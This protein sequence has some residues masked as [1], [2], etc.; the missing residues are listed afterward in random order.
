MP[1]RITKEGGI[2]K[3]DMIINF[4]GQFKRLLRGTILH[5]GNL[6]PQAHHKFVYAGNNPVN[7]IDPQ[8]LFYGLPDYVIGIGL[9][10]LGL[11]FLPSPVGWALIASGAVIMITNPISEYLIK[12]PLERIAREV[13]KRIQER[14][15]E[16]E[17]ILKG[18]Y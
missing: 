16:I 18:K 2:I 5:M 4:K 11:Y 6:N 13:G 15:K 3:P 12:R 7:W 1:D 17:K 14:N 9:I 10:G 8:G